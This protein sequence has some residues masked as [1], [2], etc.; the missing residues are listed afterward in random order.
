RMGRPLRSAEPGL[1]SH[2]L[3]RGNGRRAL[4]LKG[5]D[6][7]ALERVLEEAHARTPARLLA[8]CLMPN[9]WHLV[10]W[11]QDARALSRF[12]GRLR[13]THAQRW[14][15]HS[16]NAGTGPLYQGRFQSFPIQDRN[17][18]PDTFSALFWPLFRPRG[19]AHVPS[20]KSDVG[21]IAESRGCIRPANP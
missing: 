1:V 3:N 10:L 18:V 13:L 8:Y 19:R 16:H 21:P 11:P 14:P 9:H 12:A 4:F 5:A 7:L 20:G 2:A 6:S 15:A 17:T